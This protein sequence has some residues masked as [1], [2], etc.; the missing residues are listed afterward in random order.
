MSRP[1][2]PPGPPPRHSYHGGDLYRPQEYESHRQNESYRPNQSYQLNEDR[3]THR[4]QSQYQFRGSDGYDYDRDYDSRQ[5]S[6]SRRSP[7]R[8]RNRPPSPNNYPPHEENFTFRYDAPP[9]V[10]PSR[11]SSYRPRSPPRPSF[12]SRGDRGNGYPPEPR[13]HMQGRPNI[14][15]QRRGDM[16][17][18]RGGYRSRKASDR[19]FLQT[20]RAPTP[21]LMSGIDEDRTD[22]VR[23]RPLADVSDSDEAEISL[24][25]GDGEESQ[26]PKK[27]Q[28]RTEKKAADGD[29]V[30]QW[31]NPD[32]YTALPPPDAQKKKDM[33]KL[34]RKARVADGPETTAKPGAVDDDFIS[35]DFGDDDVGHTDHN[36]TNH[37][38]N[39]VRG[40]PT[41]PKHMQKFTAINDS[42]YPS[43]R[44][45]NDAPS[46]PTESRLAARPYDPP[47][48]E[49]LPPPPAREP[50]LVRMSSSEMPLSKLPS[51][52]PKYSVD[53][54]SDP[55]LG[56]RKRDIRDEI[57]G[58]PKIYS[59]NSGKK[60]PS[61]GKIVK[62]WRVR[63]GVPS[64]PW[65]E[66]DHSKSS[67]MGMWLHKEIIDFY[68]FVKPRDFEQVIRTKVVN[69]LRTA[70]RRQFRGFDIH[71][72][73]SFSAG[74]YLPTADMDLV[75][76]S[77]EFM[78][79]GYAYENRNMLFQF[80]NW[81]RRSGLAIDGKVECISRAK[82]PL[83]KYIDRTT[84]LRI[85]LS[86]E[87][88]TG[89]IANKTFQDW[90]VEF[91]SMPILVTLIKHI[92]AMRG[93]NEPVNG[94]IG[95]FSVICLVV[96]LLQ[97]MP[98]VQSR[99][100]IPEHH[101]GEVLMEF[102]DLYGN[103]F[104]F[105]TTAISLT[106]PAYLDKASIQ[107]IPYNQNKNSLRISIIDPNKSNNDISGGASNTPRVL[108]CFS[109]AHK[110]LQERMDYLQ[111][112]P[113]RT[114]ESILDCV[115]GGNYESFELQRNHLQYLHEELIGPV[116][117]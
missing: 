63:D 78:R 102:F 115:L 24:C 44:P 33:V 30:P 38:R 72:F 47:S 17:G 100:M 6:Y 67:N 112:L 89:L 56:S 43:N 90:K 4:P 107:N 5:S 51:K 11:G 94:G 80:A 55:A 110:D 25:E 86:F 106:P 99:S 70:V 93:L 104:N 19:A 7:P 46:G 95:G 92:L 62:G 42:Y 68:Y 73:G 81:V 10:D 9:G 84:G 58:P 59:T 60:P 77:D 28:V 117:D 116:R 87:N 79:T 61:D 109:R 45:Q 21:E 54:S 66:Y 105:V 82:V 2:L 49:R 103:E 101:L 34:I 26:Q 88:D 98:Q 3:A 23:Y 113:E 74:L 1:P 14:R 35:F 31:S 39:S 27:K 65:I 71:P 75:C 40:A 12:Q 18:G 16:R 53:L 85:D 97:Q 36:S 91:P 111:K 50:K 69:D 8:Q 52:P 108:E 64:C 20:N 41:G 76:V 57:K 83:V 96:S 29:S 48:H 15:S 37:P 13:E 114:K 32:P 22:G